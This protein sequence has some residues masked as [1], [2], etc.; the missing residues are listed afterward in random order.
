MTKG[1]TDKGTT[2]MSALVV[3]SSKLEELVKAMEE[4]R[5]TL[6]SGELAEIANINSVRDPEPLSSFNSKLLVILVNSN[7]MRAP[8]LLVLPS[9]HQWNGSG[10]G[11]CFQDVAGSQDCGSCGGFARFSTFPLQLDATCCRR[12]EGGFEECPI[13]K[14][15]YQRH[16]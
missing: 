15:C 8:H 14:A 2:A 9:R 1:V 3:R 16:F 5:E 7:N 6:P 4:I 11:P 10:R 13:Q 12:H